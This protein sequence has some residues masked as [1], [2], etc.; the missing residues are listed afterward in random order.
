MLINPIINKYNKQ[1]GSD[2][3]VITLSYNL[4]SIL[5]EL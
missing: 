3:P 2:D 1:V 4:H 5:N